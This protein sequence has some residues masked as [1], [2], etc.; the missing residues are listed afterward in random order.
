MFD[1]LKTIPKSKLSPEELD[2]IYIYLKKEIAKGNIGFILSKPDMRTLT[3]IWD[4]LIGWTHN[5]KILL[6]SKLAQDKAKEKPKKDD[7]AKEK[8][9]KDDK[10]KEKP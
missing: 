6:K 1:Y 9:K 2:F 3:K 4:K 8:P 5:F 10:A 7:K